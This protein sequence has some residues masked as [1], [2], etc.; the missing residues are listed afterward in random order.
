M[1]TPAKGATFVSRP[2]DEERATRR[3]LPWWDR[4][5]FLVLLAAVFAM[6]VWG[7]VADNPILPVSEAFREVARSRWFIFVLMGLEVLRQLNYVVQEHSTSYFRLWTRGINATNRLID[8]MSPWTRFRIA[9]VFKWVFWIGVVNWFVAWRNE[10]AFFKQLVTLPQTIVDFLLSTGEQMPLI[11]QYSMIMFIAVGQFVAIFWFLSRG[12]TEVYYP[13]DVT[14]RFSDVWGQDAVL[15]RVKENIVFLEDPESIEDRGGYVPSG[16]LLYGPPGTGKTL[17]AEAVA[18]ETGRPFVF[19]EPGAFTNMFMGVGILKVKSLFRKLRK[20]SLKYGGVIAFFDEADVLGNRGAQVGGGAAAEAAHAHSGLCHGIAYMS[21]G[22]AS[23][24]RKF[25]QHG[26]PWVP[27][28]AADAGDPPRRNILR[29]VMGGLGGGGGDMGTLQALLAELSGLKKPR[30]FF[31]RSI[32]RALG[33]RPKLPPKYRLLVMMASNMPDAL[34]PALLRPG[35][36]DRI[37]RVGYPSKAGRVRTYEGYLDKVQH[38]LTA[39]Q[40]DKLAVMTPYATGATIKDLVNEALINAIRDDRQAITWIDVLEAKHLK[41]LGPSRDVELVGQDRHGVAVHEAC[42]AV[43]AYRARKHLEIDLATI[44][45]GNE[46]LGMVASIRVDD[47]FKQFKSEFEADV[48][49]ALASLAGERIFFDG[50]SASGVSGDLEQAT[51]LTILM[52]GFWGMGTTIASHAVTTA[53]QV[54]GGLPGQGK[55]SP[56]G[57][58]LRGGLGQRVED[59]LARLLRRT[60]QMLEKDR[61]AV[62][63]LAH[64]LEVHKTLSG[65]DVVAVIERMPGPIVD[66]TLYAN[67]E[68]VSSIR[69]YHDEMLELHRQSVQKIELEAP[70]PAPTPVMAAVGASDTNGTEAGEHGNGTWPALPGAPDPDAG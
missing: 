23:T 47:R 46:Y 52:E 33:M 22:S 11:F 24:L 54:T 4:I 66:G 36:I 56:T 9:R 44:D 64:A 7:E 6:F 34:D 67:P 50:D 39:E 12:G 59:N 2:R 20:L 3:P 30:G 21:P 31:N 45:P 62:L 43:V 28:A 63:C 16:I 42:H 29:V 51:E 1:N 55:G 27:E 26:E 57:E 14:T 70:M 13:D 69:A 18:G 53:A 68:F 41:S 48:M 8:R 32:R 49:V 40:I 37:Y 60:A 15:D 35:R 19:I 65:D 10:E 58:M 5:K 25:H 61:D 38:E 17:M